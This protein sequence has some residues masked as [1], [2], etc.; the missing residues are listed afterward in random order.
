MFSILPGAAALRRTTERFSE[1]MRPRLG[2]LA[3]DVLRAAM[4]GGDNDDD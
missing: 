4:G 1:L 3:E 2:G